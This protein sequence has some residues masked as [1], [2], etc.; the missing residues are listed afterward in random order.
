MVDAYL[1]LVAR[2]PGIE[3]RF[4]PGWE[5]LDVLVDVL[6]EIVSRP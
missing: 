3:V 2:V 1:E 6:E 5:H 4:Q